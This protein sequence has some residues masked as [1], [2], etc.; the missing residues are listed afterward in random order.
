MSKTMKAHRWIVRSKGLSLEDFPVPSPSPTQVLLKVEA[1]G[2]C[3]SDLHIVADIG[4][5][6]D[7]LVT[8]GSACSGTVTEIEYKVSEFKAG[9][10]IVVAVPAHPVCVPVTGLHYAGR[11]AE[12]AAQRNRR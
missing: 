9:N 3:H 12:Y 4:W 7:R 5:L 10:R 1:C 6:P 11:Y 8:M 2:I